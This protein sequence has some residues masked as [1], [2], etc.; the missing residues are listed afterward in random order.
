MTSRQRLLASMRFE[1]VDRVPVAPFGLGRLDANSSMAK[2]LIE[3]T[4]PFID[5][6]VA[7]D[8]FFGA[9]C[10]TESRREGDTVVTIRRTPLGDLRQVY[11]YTEITSACIEH[12]LKTP[13]D[14]EKFLSI[15]YVAPPVDASE[16]HALKKEIGEQGLVLVTVCDAV[17]LPATLL[18]PD[19]FCLW[20]ADH[21]D[22]MTEL[23]A[24]GSKRVNDW[25]RRLCEAGVDAFRVV[26]GEY[27]SVQLGP[28][29]LDRLVLEQDRE[30]VDIIH[31]F[32]GIVL[33]HN[34][35]PVMRY[36]SR[37]AHI[38]MD[39]LDPLEAPP[40]GDA[41]LRA[42]RAECGERVAFAGNLDDMEILEKLPAQ[43]VRQLALE[44][45]EAAGDR[46]F[47]LGGTSSGTYTEKAARNFIEMV[48]VAELFASG[49][50]RV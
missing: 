8:Y 26:G 45:L 27:A 29:G 1:K 40:W 17:M 5:C 9:D 14:A 10:E 46:G 34:H 35:G 16:F 43:Q 4:D 21:P 36:L 22:L 18:S 50:H 37:F 25:T 15:P 19:D 44:R 20:W 12:Y 49:A 42:A 47:I 41:D 28:G 2:E 38:G 23:T 33:Y 7:G 6:G 32:G 39:V 30:L 24:I 3:K 13:E 11:R 31:S 48:A